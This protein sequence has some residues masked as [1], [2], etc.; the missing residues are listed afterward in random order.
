M[1]ILRRVTGRPDTVIADTTEEL[2]QLEAVIETGLAHFH[3]AGRALK[4]IKERRLFAPKYTTFGEYSDARWGLSLPHVTRLIEAADIVDQL[5]AAGSLKLPKIE[6]HARVLSRIEPEKRP[7]IWN[8]A[9]D[10]VGDNPTA[11]QLDEAVE[12]LVPRKPKRGRKVP[13]AIR[14][15]GKGWSLVLERKSYD[16]DAVAVLESALSQLRSTVTSKAA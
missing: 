13:K 6:S 9:I 11:E 1:D 12:Q 16:V 7:A 8:A 3:A 14:L 15:K 2:S 5:H 10:K 4:A